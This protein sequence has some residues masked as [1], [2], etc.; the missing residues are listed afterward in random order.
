MTPYYADDS[1]TLYH[2]DCLEILPSLGR[3]DVLLTDPPYFKVKD[4]EWDNQWDKAHEFLTWL[5]G[6]L[7]LAKPLLQP[8]ASVWVFASP[9]MTSSVERLVGERFRVLNSIRWVKEQGWHQKAEIESLRAFLTPWE[10]IVFAEQYDDAYGDAAT[11]LHRQVFA[12][13]GRYLQTEREC[14]GW[15]RNAVEVALG[16]VRTKNAERGTELCRR[17]EEGSSIP[18]AADYQRLRDLYAGD[19]LRREYEDLRRE[20]EDLRREY[21]DLRRPFNL[22]G[23]ANAS[24]V[25]AFPTVAPYPGKHPCEKPSSMLRHMIRTSSKRGQTIL[26]PFAGSGSTLQVAK[27]EGRRAVGVELNERYCEQAARRLSQDAFDFAAGVG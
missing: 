10:G 11:A 6:F 23:K 9:A 19:Y 17:W 22:S 2:G 26:D 20:Y 24:D 21:E 16:Y 4:D 13:L 18:T 12:P 7:D 5:G 3:A 14:A 8:H 25:W 1:V 27:E 15:E